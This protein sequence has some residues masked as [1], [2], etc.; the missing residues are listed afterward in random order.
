M[1]RRGRLGARICAAPDAGAREIDRL[2]TNGLLP[3][4]SSEVLRHMSERRTFTAVDVTLDPAGS[5]AY[6]FVDEGT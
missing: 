2:L 5:F 6:R 1:S 4:L 3:D